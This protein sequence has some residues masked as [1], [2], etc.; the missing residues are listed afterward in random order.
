MH[1]FWFSNRKCSGIWNL[2]QQQEIHYTRFR[3]LDFVATQK[4]EEIVGNHV[5]LFEEIKAGRTESIE[6]L[7]GKHLYGGLRRMGD[8][9][10]KEYGQ[11]FK[12]P[13]DLEFW[14]NHTKQYF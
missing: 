13:Q 8:K 6:F 9:V 10:L 5:Q 7:L 3:M 1:S 12:P 11:Y 4:Y 2:I 14:E